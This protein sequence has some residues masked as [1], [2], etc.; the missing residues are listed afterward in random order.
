MPLYEFYA[1]LSPNQEKIFVS[2]PDLVGC[3]TYGKDLLDA[4]DG[5]EDT[6]RCH[7][8]KLEKN[9]ERIPYA[10]PANAVIIPNGA[11]LMNIQVNTDGLHRK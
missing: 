11:S 7:L 2:F 3:F 1:I 6:L 4:L 10:C 5:A 9:G 8:F